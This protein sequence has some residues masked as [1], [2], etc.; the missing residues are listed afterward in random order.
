MTGRVPATA[1]T[2]STAS[3]RKHRASS[4]ASG[5]RSGGQSRVFTAPARGAFAITASPTGWSTGPMASSCH[6][7]RSSARLAGDGGRGRRR[8]LVLLREQAPVARARTD[9][10]SRSSAWWSWS[11]ATRTRRRGLDQRDR[12]LLGEERPQGRGQVEAW[13]GGQRGQRGVAEVG[14]VC[15]RTTEREHAGVENG[16]HRV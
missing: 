5:G 10:I 16:E 8:R 14:A 6:A 15:K 4:A 12:Q 11:W 3:S 1:P 7:D 13:I 9:A 2:R